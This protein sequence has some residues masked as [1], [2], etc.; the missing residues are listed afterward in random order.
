[1]KRKKRSMF[2]S[3]II[4]YLAMG[5][6]VIISN[7]LFFSAV[8]ANIIDNNAKS[9]GYILQQAKDMYD[10]YIG[11]LSDIA[12]TVSVSGLP[13]QFFAEGHPT[14]QDFFNT[15]EYS[16]FVTGLKTTKEY[17]RQVCIYQPKTGLVLSNNGIRP[18]KSYYEAD[19][20][21]N[22]A[23]YENFEKTIQTTRG[24]ALFSFQDIY[25]ED[26]S[27]ILFIR[28]CGDGTI[29]FSEMSTT[30]LLRHMKQVNHEA[31]G[32]ILVQDENQKIIL[33]N[34]DIDLENESKYVFLKAGSQISSWKYIY[35]LERDK[36]QYPERYVRLIILINLLVGLLFVVVY[37]YFFS[38]RNYKPLKNL[39]TKFDFEKSRQKNEFDFLQQQIEDLSQS[40]QMFDKL[41]QK[42]ADIVRMK[43]ADNILYGKYTAEDVKLFSEYYRDFTGGMFRVVL[44]CPNAAQLE[45]VRRQGYQE[46]D[47]QTIFHNLVLEVLS[48]TTTAAMF[49]T[50]EGFCALIDGTTQKEVLYDALLRA[51]ELVKTY[52]E[53][54]FS[55]VVSEQGDGYENISSLYGQ[56]TETMRYLE[57]VQDDS[58]MFYTEL[59]SDVSSYH[60]SV[61]L[62]NKMINLLKAGD[63]ENA[64]SAFEEMVDDA[65]DNISEYEAAQELLYR[66]ISILVYVS[67]AIVPN[68]SAFE[69]G[70]F[71][72][73]K[74]MLPFESFEK[75][76][77]DVKL[78]FHELCMITRPEEGRTENTIDKITHYIQAHYADPDLDATKICQVFDLHP[79]YLSRLFREK[80][81][82]G[83]LDYIAQFRISA[84]LKLLKETDDR[85]E[86][87]AAQVGYLNEKTF[88]RA[89]KKVQGVTPAKY[90]QQ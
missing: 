51:Q 90:R 89:F 46:A 11:D 55:A 38:Y 69:N 9:Y 67:A 54:E 41:N 23:D 2:V 49:T 64:Y 14:N 43:I 20:N 81:A 6:V 60:N 17:V 30:I 63:G 74:R 40:N 31:E 15:Y 19:Y 68:E 66:M 37:S 7:S 45:A 56:A 58:I 59:K 27:V 80:M 87:V 82:C 10:K 47:I 44:I 86:D 61:T 57:M 70:K 29:V 78:Y 33:G 32:Q 18:L 53:I 52:F 8:N 5:I 12:Y 21:T 50:K 4:S 75:L 35:V 85:I 62:K 13:E 72:P 36:Y 88:V 39:V 65:L 34:A 76:K 77:K 42:N 3:L 16:K 26:D 22:G 84:S 71:D 83:M 1:M 25:G 24:Y 48:E 79:A 28:D 73:V